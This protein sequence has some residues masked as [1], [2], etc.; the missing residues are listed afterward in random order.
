VLGT[1]KHDCMMQWSQVKGLKVKH[2]VQILDESYRKAGYYK[3][4]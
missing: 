3:D 1:G 4:L 2:A